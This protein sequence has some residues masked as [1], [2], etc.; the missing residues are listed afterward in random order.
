MARLKFDVRLERNLVPQVT[1]ATRQVVRSSIKTIAQDL[2]RTAS[3]SAPHLTGDLE[4]SY[5][6]AYQFGSGMVS[7]TV[8]FAVFKGS[9]NY[10]I[11]MH[12]WTYNLGEGSQAKA[13]GTGMSGQSYA[14]GRK[15]LTRVLEGE[16]EA[17]KEYIAQQLRQHLG[18]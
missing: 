9:F 14:V 11:A 1:K 3:E 5:A 12:E 17:Y 13:G 2:A 8:E 6:I 18:G 7:A 10:A 4:D 16:A 15:F